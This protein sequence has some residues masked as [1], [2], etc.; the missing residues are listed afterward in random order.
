MSALSDPAP[1][2][3][4]Y[5]LARLWRRRGVRRFVLSQG[6][7][8][9]LALA[10]VRLAADPATHAAVADAAER[11]RAALTAR[12]E[13]AIRRLVIEGASPPVE[14]EIR[15]A[16]GDAVGASSLDLD[17]A[18][19]RRRLEDLGWVASAR[20]SLEAP[21][22][23]RV[24]VEERRAVALWRIDGEPWLIAR[25]GARIAPAFSRAD[26]PDLPLLAGDGAERA[27]PEALAVLKAAGPVTERVRGLV[28]VGDR[29]WD[30][31]LEPPAADPTALASAADPDAP[32]LVAE[33]A[34]PAPIRIMLPAEGAAQAMRA[35]VALHRAKGVLDAAVTRFDLRLPG[36]P[37]L[38]LTPEAQELMRLRRLPV[39]GG[40]DA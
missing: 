33:A 12:P 11:M 34:P 15:A 5:R 30:V 3:L 7:A 18:A 26:H 40:R 38:R 16:L 4:R 2:R 35:A 37:T 32:A 27:V 22:A 23:L 17:A 25:D 9:L 8:L 1:S 10:L 24:A 39:L 29:R 36:R 14:A 28:R 13:F 21:E 6:P 19:A 20:V 31:V